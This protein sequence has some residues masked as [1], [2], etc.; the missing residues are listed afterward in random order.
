[1]LTLSEL[2]DC[3]KCHGKIVAIMVNALGQMCCGYCGEIVD[4]KK[5]LRFVSRTD[6]AGFEEVE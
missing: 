6:Y 5:R 1:M 4:Y 3:Q 2:H